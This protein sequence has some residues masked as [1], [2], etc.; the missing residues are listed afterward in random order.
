MLRFVVHPPS[1]IFVMHPTNNVWSI[2]HEKEIST[3]GYHVGIEF[4]GVVYCNVH[5]YGLLEYDWENDFIG[6]GEK[7]VTKT[8]F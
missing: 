5:Y 3:N 8:E 6:V 7:K 1:Y 4:L 2:M